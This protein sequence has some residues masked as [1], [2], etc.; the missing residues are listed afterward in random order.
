MT[1]IL[2]IDLQL[3]GYN[4][5][6]E[7]LFYFNCEGSGICGYTVTDRTMKDIMKGKSHIS[8]QRRTSREQ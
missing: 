1:L 3:V 5:R 4:L 8:N 7:A 6:V 2:S